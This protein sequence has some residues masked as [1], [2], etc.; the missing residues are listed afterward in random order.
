MGVVKELRID[1]MTGEL[2]SILVK[3]SDPAGGGVTTDIPA[4]QVDVGGGE[5]RLIEGAVPRAGVE[6]D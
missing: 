6:R 3:E 1:D 4:D 2:R 5:V